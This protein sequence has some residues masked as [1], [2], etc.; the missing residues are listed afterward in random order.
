MLCLNLCVDKVWYCW[1]G[2]LVFIS[3]ITGN[4]QARTAQ[5][6]PLLHADW[7]PR[8]E[9]PGC[10]TGRPFFPCSGFI[11]WKSG[12]LTARGFTWIGRSTCEVASSSFWG[13]FLGFWRP[14][15][16]HWIRFVRLH[17]CLDV[18][19]WTYMSYYMKGSTSWQGPPLVSLF[20]FRNIGSMCFIEILHVWV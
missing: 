20:V 3:N 8:G 5:K 10:S 19:S 7:L 16:R 18:T 17:W 11:W 14:Y 2:V 13:G 9:L 1:L 4:S 6:H 15:Q 12:I